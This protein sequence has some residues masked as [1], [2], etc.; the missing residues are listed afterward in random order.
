MIAADVVLGQGVRVHHPDLVNL[1]GCRIGDGCNIGA[2]VEIQRDATLGRNVKVQAFAFIPSGVTIEDGVFV[3]PHACFTNDHWPRAVKPDLTPAGA[4]DWRVV[5]TLVRQGAS[6][7]ANA[8][9]RCG[10]TIGRWAMVAA[11]AVVTRDVPDHTLVAGV[12]AR[13]VGDTRDRE[14]AGA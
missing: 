12:P 9:I 13:V 10:V 8:T 1:Y 3:G 14:A 4:A 5:P 11:G 2:F 7:G 6:I